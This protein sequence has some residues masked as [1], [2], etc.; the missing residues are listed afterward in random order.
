MNPTIQDILRLA[1]GGGN[2]MNLIQQFLGGQN[3]RDPKTAQALRLI[4]GKSPEE[5]EQTARNLAKEAGTTPEQILKS[6][7]I[8]IPG[9]R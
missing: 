2:P 3:S 5:L 8:S 9:G 6:L 7:G 4:Q 1:A